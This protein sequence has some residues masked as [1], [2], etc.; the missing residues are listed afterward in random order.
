MN[1]S[2]YTMS[3]FLGITSYPGGGTSSSD[4]QSCIFPVQPLRDLTYLRN[5]RQCSYFPNTSGSPITISKACARVMA[6]NKTHVSYT[7]N[8]SMEDTNDRPF[9]RWRFT[10]TPNDFRRWLSSWLRVLA[11]II[12]FRSW[13]KNKIGVYISSDNLHR[14]VPGIARR[15]PPEYLIV[16]PPSIIAEQP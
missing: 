7:A 6:A 10:K 14:P 16:S 1:S 11:K 5:V 8:I 13:L 3:P 15:I 12:T 9:I 4:S 2:P